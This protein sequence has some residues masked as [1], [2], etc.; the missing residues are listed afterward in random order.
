MYTFIYIYIC[1]CSAWIGGGEPTEWPSS[2]KKKLIN[3]SL[4]IFVDGTPRTL[5]CA[6]HD[7]TFNSSGTHICIPLPI[8]FQFKRWLSANRYSVD[9]ART[10]G[11]ESGPK[12]VERDLIAKGIMRSVI[13]FRAAFV[14]TLC[15]DRFRGGSHVG[16]SASSS[17]QSP[18]RVWP[19][20]RRRYRF[21]RTRRFLRVTDVFS[22]DRFAGTHEVF[23]IRLSIAFACVR[24]AARRIYYM[25]TRVYEIWYYV[26]TTTVMFAA[27][28]L[29]RSVRDSYIRR[30]ITFFDYTR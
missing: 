2:F 25:H 6:S 21:V 3:V 18:A 27:T 9:R 29:S 24:Y 4:L 23:R 5:R 8:V 10:V 16:G 26:R 7:G 1:I 19:R 28:R 12:T 17:A 20:R 13:S 15:G 30:N 11:R 14:T 22:G